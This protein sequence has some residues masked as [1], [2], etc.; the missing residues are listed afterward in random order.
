MWEWMNEKRVE[1][2]PDYPRWQKKGVNIFIYFLLGYHKG[3]WIFFFLVFRV[4]PIRLVIFSFGGRTE[5]SRKFDLASREEK[6]RGGFIEKIL[7]GEFIL[8]PSY[9]KGRRK[10]EEEEEEGHTTRFGEKKKLRMELK[11][12]REGGGSRWLLVPIHVGWCSPRI[13]LPK[14]GSLPLSFNSAIFFECGRHFPT[15]TF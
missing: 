4:C 2:C 1:N 14:T 13:S 7:C 6:R 12:K 10:E 3:K 9:E 8:P 15:P 5:T 11:R